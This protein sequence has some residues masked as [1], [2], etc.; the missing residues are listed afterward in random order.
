MLLLTTCENI[1]LGFII[2]SSIYS[3][4]RFPDRVGK[5]SNIY[6]DILIMMA[7]Q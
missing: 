5:D 7:K 4:K 6:L 1:R 3:E 2:T